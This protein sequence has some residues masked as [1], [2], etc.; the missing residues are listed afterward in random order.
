MN[1]GKFSGRPPGYSRSTGSAKEEA[2]G[3]GCL[4]YLGKVFC[5]ELMAALTIKEDYPEDGP[6]LFRVV[7]DVRMRDN[8][9]KLK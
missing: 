8:G 2:A 7:L 3:T 5:G 9:C 4:Y 6:R 1:W